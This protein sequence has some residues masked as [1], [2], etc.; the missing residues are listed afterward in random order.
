MWAQQDRFANLA[1][2]GTAVKAMSYDAN[3]IY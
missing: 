1:T 2:S 3:E